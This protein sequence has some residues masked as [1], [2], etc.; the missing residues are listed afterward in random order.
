MKSSNPDTAWG[1]RKAGTCL[2]GQRA[3]HDRV[4]AVAEGVE[5]LVAAPQDVVLEQVTSSAVE[6]E[7]RQIEL[8]GE[9]CKT[10]GRTR[11]S[12]T[13]PIVA[14]RRRKAALL[15]QKTKQNGSFIPEIIVANG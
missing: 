4:D 15:W 2:Y 8:H 5:L 1:Q 3:R 9:V 11:Q 13:E 10:P 14:G 12:R 6:L 7:K